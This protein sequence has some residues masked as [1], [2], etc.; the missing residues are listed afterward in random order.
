MKTAHP[1][2]GLSLTLRDDATLANFYPGTD[3]NR[4]VLQSLQ[5]TLLAQGPRV[6]FLH[7]ASGCG[8]SHLLQAMC[9]AASA[10]Q[11]T[12]MYLPLQEFV[13]ESPDV[14]A[15]LEGL[16]LVCLDDVQ[17]VLGKADW[18]EALFHFMNRLRDA[19]RFVLLASDQPPQ[20]L[21]V[22]L[23]DLQSRLAQ[24]A[25]F[26][27]D[28]LPDDA[29]Q[30]WLQQRAL[31]RGLE[32]DEDVARFVIA[33]APR[34]TPAVLAVLDRLDQEALAQQRKLTVPFIKQVLGW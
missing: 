2:L 30:A 5:S 32:L 4:L 16:D 23:P 12:A 21:L 6:I 20:Q 25:V 31:A 26:R 8:C 17:S 22:Q 3:T 27:L 14:L 7:G 13:H 9:H 19:G 24:A 1:Q 28:V 11:K 18:E 34:S 33:R 15:G 10:Q 29:R